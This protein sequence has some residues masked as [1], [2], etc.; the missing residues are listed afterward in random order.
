MVQM[1]HAHA[2]TKKRGNAILLCISQ[3]KPARHGHKCRH[4]QEELVTK[5]CS[6]M[7]Q[8]AP[9]PH[10]DMGAAALLQRE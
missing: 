1:V 10:H 4:P 9:A 6:K 7:Q 5:P 2:F 3:P 8:N